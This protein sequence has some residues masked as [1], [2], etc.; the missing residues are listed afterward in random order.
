MYCVWQVV[1]TPTIISKNPVF[2]QVS[3][4]CPILL[5]RCTYILFQQRI[6]HT[7]HQFPACSFSCF[8]AG[9]YLASMGTKFWMRRPSS[10]FCR[11]VQVI[12]NF[13]EEIFRDIWKV[14]CFSQ[15]FFYFFDCADANIIQGLSKRFERFKFGIFYVLIVKIRYNFTHK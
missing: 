4:T 2:P 14:S 6:C 7:L 8:S 13:R 1:K 11:W 3:S 10:V 9:S 15:A 12:Q 5:T